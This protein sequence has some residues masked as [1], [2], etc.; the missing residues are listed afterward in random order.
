MNLVPKREY[1]VLLVGDI[2]VFAAALWLT[3]A[4]RY[5]EPPSAALFGQHI[6]PF[7]MLFVAWVVV[8]FL[9]GLYGRHTR[10]FR[11]GLLT[12]IVSAQLI[13]IVI[14]ALFFFFVPAFGLAPKTILLLYL[15]VSSPLVFLWRVSIFP[16][17]RGKKRMRGILIASG[18]DARALADE[19]A[20][21]K[22][23]PF[24]FEYVL[25]TKESP[26]HEVI[27]RACR[28]IAEDEITFLVVDFADRAVSAAL[29]ILYDAAFRK[30]R[31]ALVDAVELYQEVFECEPLS[32][33][34]YDW[35]LGNV[36]VSRAY[37]VLKR[38]ID[39]LGAI[40]AGAVSL[41]VYPFVIAAIKMEDGGPIFVK[42][43]RVGRY[44]Q[45][46][47]ILKF[48]SMTGNDAGDYGAS[49]KSKLHVT[50]VGRWLR[51]FRID[52]L[53]QIWNI[54]RGDL[55]FV[56]PRPEAPALAN[57]YNARISYYSAR[58]LIKPGLTGWAQLR[59]D[60]HPHHGLAIEETKEKLSYD[61][62]YLKHRSLFL[63]I[64]IML[65]TI[66]IVVTARGS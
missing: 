50:K 55:S 53:P 56:G 63:D 7:S 26:P 16:Q 65:Q 57:N 58:H 40:F 33:M 49:G 64:F 66:R 37:D 47:Q 8:F 9:A 35:I 32:L 61:L 31:F 2:A 30:P 38:M 36:S 17:L 39:I 13:N 45:Q 25:D 12:T 51:L 60:R 43:P 23:S 46:I 4:L 42:L 18:P 29:P 5:L 19:V 11:S 27:Q 44:Q 14:A 52:E 20:K 62:Y 24:E 48:R 41:I 34:T 54:L 3:L 1:A 15:L 22:R 6:V 21:D 10:L 59:H 28:F